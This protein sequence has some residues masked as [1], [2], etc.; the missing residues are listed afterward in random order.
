MPIYYSVY[1]F[2]FS[3][4]NVFSQL[5]ESCWNISHWPHEI[6]WPIRDLP[7]PEPHAITALLMKAVI[8]SPLPAPRMDRNTLVGT[9][10]LYV[11]ASDLQCGRLAQQVPS[12]RIHLKQYRRVFLLLISSTDLAAGHS[13]PSLYPTPWCKKREPNQSLPTPMQKHII[14]WNDKKNLYKF[15]IPTSKIIDD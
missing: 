1:T 15:P 10:A 14:S 13:R 7:Y 4:S 3:F 8:L 9:R 6:V 12:S 5:S 2:P 11:Q